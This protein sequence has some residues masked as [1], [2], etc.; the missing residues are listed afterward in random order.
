MNQ[1][2]LEKIFRNG[3]DGKHRF[4]PVH[5]TG[6][7]FSTLCKTLINNNIDFNNTSIQTG[8]WIPLSWEVPLRLPATLI[9]SLEIMRWLLKAGINPPKF[10]VYQATSVISKVNGIEKNNALATSQIMEIQLL[11]FIKEFF[12]DVLPYIF[13]SFWEKP[14]DKDILEKIYCYAEEIRG[15]LDDS[16][17]SYFQSCE[18][19]NSKN[20]GKSLMYLAANNYYNGWFSEYPFDEVGT[21]IPIGWRSESMFF[22]ILL[23]TQQSC[24]NIFPLITQVGE[25]PTYYK[26]PRWDVMKESDIWNI[27]IPSNIK[28]DLEVL[29]LY[30]N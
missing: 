26:N 9:P 28:K 27:T 12:S 10:I 21:V 2:A 25:F 22:R 23:E 30:R 4:S 29:S 7:R 5:N 11:D 18:D 6:E 17:I 3:S 20:K 16:I 19:K 14:D 24:R 15:V 1:N 8:F 13:F